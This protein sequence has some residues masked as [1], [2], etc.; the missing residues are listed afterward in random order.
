MVAAYFKRAKPNAKI[1]A[2][3]ANP[4]VVMKSALFRLAWQKRYPGMIDYRPNQR[5]IKVDHEK[6][7]V[8]TASGE[9]KGHVVNVVPPQMAAPIAHQ[10]GLVGPDKRWCPVTPTTFE[11]TLVP[12]IHVIGDA[13]LAEPMPKTGF[14]ANAQAKVCALNMV[15]TMNGKKLIDPSSANVTY[16]WVSD[17]E[18]I[19][20][21]AVYR[22]TNGKIEEVPGSG[23]ISADLSETEWIMGIGW[24]TNILNEMSS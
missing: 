13:C 16:S 22:V 21:V 6:M 1:I 2:L 5:V 3:D 4:D 10:G 17:A 23:G 18:A 11:S 7:T 24:M 8:Y 19:S 20:T 15:A 12:N 14:S 9:V